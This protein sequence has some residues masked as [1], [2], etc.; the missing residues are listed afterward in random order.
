MALA[1]ALLCNVTTA[2]AQTIN[3]NIQPSWGPEGYDYAEFYYIPELN[4]YYD[5]INGLFYYYASRHWIG[6]QYLPVKYKRYDLHSMYKVVL[7]GDPCPWLDNRIHRVEYRHFINDRTQTPIR[8]TTEPIYEQPRRNIHPWVNNQPRNVR[9]NTSIRHTNAREVERSVR[10]ER[11]EP[12]ER[13]SEPI[14]NESRERVSEPM[15]NESRE[16]G[17]SNTSIRR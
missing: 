16:R 6:A 3:I 5:V 15:R 12:R 11:S 1:C 9:S 4:I 7:N 17:G 10:P 14:R 2:E 8:H 13:M